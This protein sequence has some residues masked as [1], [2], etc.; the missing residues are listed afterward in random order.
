MKTIYLSVVALLSK[1]CVDSI[2]S[3]NEDKQRLDSETKLRPQPESYIAQLNLDQEQEQ[4]KDV[5]SRRNATKNTFISPL[6]AL[7]DLH[8]EE[9]TAFKL[10]PVK[11]TN[12]SHKNQS[13]GTRLTHPNASFLLNDTTD[14]NSRTHDLNT[15]PQSALERFHRNYVVS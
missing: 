11:N 13:I 5:Q 8:H 10:Q 7:E 1:I 4:G 9:L 3:N 12:Q 6:S 15:Q 14:K 2:S